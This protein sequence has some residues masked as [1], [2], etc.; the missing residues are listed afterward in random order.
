MARLF[1]LIILFSLFPSVSHA[2]NPDLNWKTAFTPH[3]RIHYAEEYQNQVE[4]VAQLSEYYYQQMSTTFNWQPETAI[5]V[6][7]TD[8]VDHPNGSATPYPFNLMILQLSPP[9]EAGV[10]EDYDDWLSLLIEHEMTHIFHT[11]KATGAAKSLRGI[12]GRHILLFPNILQP[13]WLIEGIATFLETHDGI[14]RGQSSYFEMLMRDEIQQGLMP[15]SQLNLP[16]DSWPLNKHYLYG[17]YFYQFLSQRYSPEAIWRMIESYSDNVLPFAINSNSRQ[18][19]NKNLEM[20]WLE[21]E[22]YLA[23]HFSQQ[24]KTIQTA[25]LKEGPVIYQ[26][27]IVPSV[28]HTLTDG[29]VLFIDNN[30]EDEAYLSR[31]HNGHVEPLTTVAGGS[32]FDVIDDNHVL[33][34]QQEF[35][36]EHSIYYDLYLYQFSSATL[37]QLTHCSRYKKAA[38]NPVTHQIAALKTIDS[39][40]QIDLLDTQ[41]RFIKTLWK[42]RYGDAINQLDWSPARQRLLV[43]KKTENLS[44]G[45]YELAPDTA[46]W[47]PL[48]TDHHVRMQP[49][50]SVDQH[51]IYY[52]ADVTGI[53]NIYRY[54]FATATETAV[55]NVSSG[56]FN[57]TQSADGLLYYLQY[58]GEGFQLRSLHNSDVTAVQVKA[59]TTPAAIHRVDQTG[60]SV[61]ETRQDY[62]PYDDLMP[63]YWFPTLVLLDNENEIG[64]STSSNDSLLNHAYLLSLSYLTDHDEWQGNFGYAYSNWFSIYLEREL[65]IF[66]DPFTLQNDRLRSTDQ[67]QAVFS[68]PFTQLKSKW[69]Y[70]LGLVTYN[71][72]DLVVGPGIV[73]VADSNDDVVG[74]AINFDNKLSF[75]K[76]HTPETG[77]NVLLVTETSD[78]FSS[79]YEGQLQ[80]LE[81]REY[82]HLGNH[83][84]LALRLLK[85]EADNTMRP[86]SLGG[87]DTNWDQINIFNPYLSRKIF[88]KRQYPLR[89]YAS[90]AAT[91]HNLEML[92]LEWRF[93]IEQVEKGLMAPPL[94]LIK[95]SGRIF[96]DSGAAWDDGIEPN[97]LTSL[98]AEWVF[99]INLFYTYNIQARLGLAKGLDDQLGDDV[100][101]VEIGSSF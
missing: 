46:R 69:I 34:T 1:G 101:Y 17:Y 100:L 74:I 86:Y 53:Y 98:G 27:T 90:N 59:D 93:P 83:H 33:I 2:L 85:G 36:G 8:H 58:N 88:N 75:L 87:V 84:A 56:A 43:S 37:R 99:D 91:G 3:F 62:S 31:W 70:S 12:F 16:P 25:P 15:V 60:S 55:S 82:F 38:V 65:L 97:Y 94:G 61:I 79:D 14:G 95:H 32:Y 28:I 45:L 9:D 24:F 96:V 23:Q 6:V 35:C 78:L 77:R 66:S 92:S 11:D 68:L 29:S 39:I 89:G 54:D 50:Y 48:L 44:W 67:M 19:F 80:T 47:T 42:G 71:D 41:A 4:R 40:P 21:F 81:W 7:I 20:L 26:K 30:Y 64:F 63:H 72:A 52:T 18:N 10:L 73:P 57:P 49:Q 22:Q 13:G 51:S 76:S 5:R